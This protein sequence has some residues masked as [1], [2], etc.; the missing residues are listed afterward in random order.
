M[1]DAFDKMSIRILEALEKPLK[2]LAEFVTEL[3]EGKEVIESTLKLLG[4]EPGTVETATKVVEGVTKAL[5]GSGENSLA[6]AQAQT[7]IDMI[8]FFQGFQNPLPSFTEFKEG[9][10]GGSSGRRNMSTIIENL[11]VTVSDGADV[12]RETQR[13]YDKAILVNQ[14]EEVGPPRPNGDQ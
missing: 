9:T 8:K 6:Q 7:V 12:G 5:P 10:V 14:T 13:Q 2:K 1:A 4:I 3:T 11:N